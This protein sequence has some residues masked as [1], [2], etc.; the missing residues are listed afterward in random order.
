MW[1]ALIEQ[2][3][4]NSRQ[5][6]VLQLGVGREANSSYP[7]KEKNNRML[8]HVVQAISSRYLLTWYSTFGGAK[9]SELVNKDTA[10]WSGYCVAQYGTF[11]NSILA[12]LWRTPKRYCLGFE[13]SNKL[14]K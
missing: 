3:I 14:R 1:T 7:K 4:R 11:G 9:F 12:I 13:Q 10:P 2:A 6:V 8:R 5:G